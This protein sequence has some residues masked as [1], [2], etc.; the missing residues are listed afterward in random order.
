IEI[1]AAGVRG[2]PFEDLKQLGIAAEGRMLAAT[3]GINT[4]RGAI[5]CL[6]MLCAAAGACLWLSHLPVRM[7]RG[8]RVGSSPHQKT[9]SHASIGR[10]G[11]LTRP[12][13]SPSSMTKE[14]YPH[15]VGAETEAQRPPLTPM[16]LRAVLLAQWG[17]AL[18]AHTL[19]VRGAAAASHGQ[20][21]AQAYAVGGAR[22]EMAQ[23]LPAVFDIALPALRATLAAG[24]GVR[25]A[26][27][28]ALFTLMAHTSDTNVYHRG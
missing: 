9:T 24:R 11:F 16:A 22:E 5:F 4:H 1:S 21:V 25:A 20:R 28:D 27:V 14:D 10:G 8:G 15:E 26:Q 19:P 13:C 23:G 12:A 7:E 18:A 2:A 3:S 6:G 17:S